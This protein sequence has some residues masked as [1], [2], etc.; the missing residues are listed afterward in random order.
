[1]KYNILS[2][3]NSPADIKTLDTQ[4]LELLCG[5]IRDKLIA[6]VSKNGGHLASN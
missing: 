3:I 6:T 1:M 2:K 4:G 5:E